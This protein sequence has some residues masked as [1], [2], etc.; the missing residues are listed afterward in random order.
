MYYIHHIPNG[1][2][3]HLPWCVG[4]CTELIALQWYEWFGNMFSSNIVYIYMHMAKNKFKII[5]SV[6]L[7]NKIRLMLTSE[8]ISYGG[9]FLVVVVCML[10]QITILSWSRL[11]RNAWQIFSHCCLESYPELTL[12]DVLFSWSW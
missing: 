6:T 10:S 8:R 2:E 11:A 12:Y 7:R 4:I 5:F 9:T 1:Q 3:L